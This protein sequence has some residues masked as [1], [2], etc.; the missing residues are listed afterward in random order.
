MTLKYETIYDCTGN[1]YM[2]YHSHGREHRLNAPSS[3]W[4]DGDMLWFQY[5]KLHRL[6]GPAEMY[7]GRSCYYIRGK[8]YTE[9]AYYNVTKISSLLHKN[10]RP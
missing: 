10:K 7:N 8:K 6:D 5:N 1:Q 3:I 2:R 9:E 4:D